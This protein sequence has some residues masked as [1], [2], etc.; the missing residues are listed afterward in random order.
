MFIVITI[1]TNAELTRIWLLYS[2][3]LRIIAMQ[4]TQ[5][6][7]SSQTAHTTLQVPHAAANVPRKI[8]GREVGL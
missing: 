6:F 4:K 2:Y 5:L 7:S 1:F 3:G 8:G